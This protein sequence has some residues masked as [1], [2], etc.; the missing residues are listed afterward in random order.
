MD[1]IKIAL[2]VQH[3]GCGLKLSVGIDGQKRWQSTVPYIGAVEIEIDDVE[4]AHYLEITLSGKQPHHTVL[5]D[6]GSIVKDQ[7][8]LI[9]NITFDSV[10][11]GHVFTQKSLYKHNRNGTVPEITEQFF[12]EM[13]CNGTIRLDFTTPVY[14]WL[15]ENM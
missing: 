1:K 12:G 5:D 3:P 15:L 9:K 7:V 4:S 10:P 8:V 11:L 2:E 6:H 14:L 13:G